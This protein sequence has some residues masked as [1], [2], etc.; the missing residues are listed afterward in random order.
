MNL[1]SS[2]FTLALVIL[3]IYY[4]YIYF[5]IDK[6]ATTLFY[7][8]LLFL[9]ALLSIYPLI[10]PLII[11]GV[12]WLILTLIYSIKYDPSFYKRWGKN[13]KIQFKGIIILIVFLGIYIIISAFYSL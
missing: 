2:Y 10:I 13:R 6:S 9:F 3:A 1:I 12:T 5:K 4:V 8:I 7:S 11:I